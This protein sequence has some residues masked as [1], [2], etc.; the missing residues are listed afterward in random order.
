M[1]KLTILIVLGVGNRKYYGHGYEPFIEIYTKLAKTLKPFNIEFYYAIH[2]A[3][4]IRCKFID[5]NKTFS[6]IDHSNF[7]NIINEISPNYILTPDYFSD[8]GQ[9]TKKI[10]LN[11]NIPIIYT[12]R[13]WFPHGNSFYLDTKGLLIDSQIKE[14]NLDDISIDK[15]FMSWKQ[16]KI[17]KNFNNNIKKYHLILL[18]GDFEMYDKTNYRFSSNQEFID[19]V[20]LNN[21]NESFIVR[22]HPNLPLPNIN[23]YHNIQIDKNLDVYHSISESISIIGLWS[24]AIIESFLTD[25]PIFGLCNSEYTG[26]GVLYESMDLFPCINPVSKKMIERR[27]KFLSYLAYEKQILFSDISNI[28]NLNKNKNFNNIFGSFIP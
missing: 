27:N 23:K 25:K 1:K 22:P 19:Y 28:N 20:A 3:S 21:K 24:T 9:T 14:I 5:K 2:P 16:K 6:L 17:H 8:G 7:Q 26:H 15:K 18:Q 13:G 10:A 12:E 4:I 11:N